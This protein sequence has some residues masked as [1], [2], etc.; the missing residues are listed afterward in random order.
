MNTYK[1]RGRGGSYCYPTR[2]GAEHKADHSGEE[3]TQSSFTI[4]DRCPNSHSSVPQAP[5]PAQNISSKPTASG[6]WWT[7][8]CSRA[9]RNCASAT[10]LAL[11]QI[12][13][14]I[15]WVVL[16]HA[17]L[18]H[19]GYVPR[20]VRDGFR[21]PVFA[22]AATQGTLRAAASRLR[23]PDGRGRG[24]TPPRHG[25]SSHKPP[26]PLYTQDEA[27]AA[28]ERFREIPRLG[29]YRISPE[30]LVRSH[31]AGHILGASQP[32]AGD[33]R[34]RSRKS[35]CFSRATWAAT[36]SRF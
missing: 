14:T 30:F 18:D 3:N 22:D 21:G 10:G 2:R 28:L 1:K 11:P 15:D 34:R 16:T 5:S 9:A 6:C 35:P 19:T 27:L 23:A 4:P 8:A 31:N 33:H 26:L 13:A 29:E 32:G 20:L 12:P 25:Y 17:H 36:T 7:A 24:G